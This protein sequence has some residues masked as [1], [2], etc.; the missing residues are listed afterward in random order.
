VASA[1]PAEVARHLLTAYVVGLLVYQLFPFD[2]VLSGEELAGQAEHGKMILTPFT[3]GMPDVDIAVRVLAFVPV[4]F[5]VAVR[6]K[7]GRLPVLGAV[8]VGT[9]YVTAVEVLQ[10]FVFSRYSSATDVVLGA[11]G[12]LV[13][14][15]LATRFGP[16]ATRPLPRGLGWRVTGWLVRLGLTSAL[17]TMLVWGKW[18]PLD[19]RLP[20]EGLLAAL[21]ERVRVPFYYQYWNSEFEAAEQLLRDIAAPAVLGMLLISLL[22]AG[23]PGRRLA[24]GVVGAGVAVVVELGQIAFPPHVPDATTAVL[25]AGAAFA[26]VYLYGPFVKAFIHPAGPDGTEVGLDDPT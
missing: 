17:A 18:R 3:E 21:A 26:G 14:G 9:A 23:L 12:A 4:G 25:A 7:G 6:R 11:G 19:F 22:P 13:G 20:E 16:A 10:M 2:V 5:W 1:R 15:V 24:A 8:V